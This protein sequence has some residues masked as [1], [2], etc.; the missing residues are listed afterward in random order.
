MTKKRDVDALSDERRFRRFSKLR[1]DMAA[2]ATRT[3]NTRFRRWGA[4]QYE[5]DLFL[6]F[7]RARPIG[8]DAWRSIDAPD[9]LVLG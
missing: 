9:I 8:A 5:R 7:L 3:M 4:G 1:S 2:N 6:T